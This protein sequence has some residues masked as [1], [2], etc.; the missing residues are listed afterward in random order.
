ME[1]SRLLEYIDLF[2]SELERLDMN[3]WN[4]ADG[5]V[6]SAAE[7]LFE[8]TG[9]SKFRDYILRYADCYV[10][11][12]GSIRTYKPLEYKLD[13]VQPGRALLFAYRET[14]EERYILAAK[15]LLGQLERQPRTAS[16]SYWHKKIY[17]EQV[18]LDGLYMAQPFRMAYDTRYGKKDAYTDI[19]RQFENVRRNMRDPDTGLYYHG[20]DESRSV[21]WADRKTG[22]SGSFWLRSIGWLLMA[23]TDTAE[24]MDR[25]V[26]DC[27]RPLQDMYKDAVKALLNYRCAE[28][29]LL[30]QVVDRPDLE[31]NY[32]ETSGSAMTAASIFKACRLRLVLTEK[33]LPAA[34]NILSSLIK[35][36]LRIKDGRPVLTDT[37]SVAGLGPDIGRRDGTAEYYLSEPR[38]DDDS[39]GAAALFM[40]YAQYLMLKKTEPCV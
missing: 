28:N 32:C 34:E 12:D 17:P 29:G 20:F 31:G 19:C 30:L 38:A 2:Y 21:F 6:L 24:E 1:F 18:W 7:Q 13:D 39:K 40:A 10:L 26:Y 5:C 36:K 27:L 11:P 8:A 9:D 25:R 14:G 37:C 3:K 4:Y 35:E 16:G 15:N 23:L 33:Y 22:L